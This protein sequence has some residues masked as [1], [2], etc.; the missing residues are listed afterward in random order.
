MVTID[1]LVGE[2]GALCR[3]ESHRKGSAGGSLSHVWR[4]AGRKVR[5]QHGSAA[6]RTASR[7]PLSSLR[8]SEMVRKPSGDREL[9]SGEARRSKASLKQ[10]RGRCAFFLQ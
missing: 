6:N 4:K 8:K 10:C 5:T 2:H 1:H 7:P 3:H 9:A